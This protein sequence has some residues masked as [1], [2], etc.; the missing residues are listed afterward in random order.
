MSVERILRA[1]A[2]EEECERRWREAQLET[3]WIIYE[4]VSNGLEGAELGRLLGTSRQAV[5]QRV[6]RVK[7][8]IESMRTERTG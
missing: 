3:S 8:T 1:K 7:A 4:E 5:Y 6:D 2:Y